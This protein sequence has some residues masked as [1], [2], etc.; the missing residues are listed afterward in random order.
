L[1]N[2]LGTNMM[3]FLVFFVF[4]CWWIIPSISLAGPGFDIQIVNATPYVIQKTK[5]SS[6]QMEWKPVEKVEPNSVAKFYAEFKETVFKYSIDDSADADYELGAN[7]VKF[8]IRAR[9]KGVKNLPSPNPP[10]K[11]GYGVLVEWNH[12]PDNIF[13]FPISDTNNK[14]SAGWIHDGVVTVGIGYCPNA[15]QQKVSSYPT[16]DY[17]DGNFDDDLTALR[18]SVKHWAKNWME[19]YAPCIESLMLTELT[20]PGTHDAGTYPAK[21]ATQYWSQTQYLNIHD[22]LEQ[23]VRAVDLRLKI[24][25]SGDDRFQIT[26]DVYLMDLSLISVLDQINAFLNSTNKEIVILD[27]HRFVDSWS[28][29]DFKDLANLIN[30]KLKDKL[31]PPTAKNQTLG[32]IWKTQGRVVVGS[33]KFKSSKESFWDDAVKQHWSSVTTWSNI[34]SYMDGQLEKVHTPKDHLWALMAQYNIEAGRKPA[35]VPKELSSYFSGLNGLKAN[36]IHVDWWN[37][38][39][40][41]TGHTETSTPNFSTLINAVPLNVLKGYRKTNNLPLW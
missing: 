14:S 24:K 22:Q 25:G 23:G 5:S 36:I 28:D 20:L 10:S 17:G 29:Q 15:T 34:E 39:N 2:F 38:V 35:Y 3:R 32:E 6:Y 40:A 21:G 31:I 8:T 33:R 13:V 27:F 16:P 26:H 11:S 19:L 7:R 12:L 9:K 18:P 1:S 37:R 41:E 4:L 30:K